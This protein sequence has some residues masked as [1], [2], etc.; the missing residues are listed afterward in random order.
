MSAGRTC[1]LSY[2]YAPDVMRAE[3]ALRTETLYVVGGLYGNEPALESVVRMFDAEPGPKH[4]IFNGDFNW[5]D[6]VSICSDYGNFPACISK[7]EII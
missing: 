3:P 2:R 7:P 6:I 4:L 1:P 5:F